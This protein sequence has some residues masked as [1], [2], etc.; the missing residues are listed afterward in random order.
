VPDIRNGFGAPAGGA[1]E[2]SRSPGSIASFAELKTDELRVVTNVAGV[3]ASM[4][5]RLNANGCGP[6]NAVPA[7]LKTFIVM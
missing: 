1:A 7:E 6:R 3:P 5:A 2:P 4:A